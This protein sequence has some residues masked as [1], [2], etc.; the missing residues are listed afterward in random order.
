MKISFQDG[1]STLYNKCV[2]CGSTPSNKTPTAISQSIEDIYNT[3]YNEGYEDGN[4]SGSSG[5]MVG[6][7]IASDV[8]SGKTFTNSTSV[9]ISGTMKNN[10]TLN[11]SDENT[12]KTITPGYYSGGTLDS[13]PSYNAG[14]DA[15]YTEGKNDGYEQGYEE[16]KEEGSIDKSYDLGTLT[17]T[18]ENQTKTLDC[19]SVPNYQSLTVDNF[20]YKFKNEF[21]RNNSADAGGRITVELWG[22][23]LAYNAETGT[24]SVRNCYA[25]AAAYQ[26]GMTSTFVDSISFKVIP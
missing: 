20:Y 9:G 24:L 7:A 4:D 21:Y 15:G 6:T 1:V 25:K 19:K 22:P 8:L 5:S 2:S 26:Y 12:T 14:H 11:W 18:A 16:G 13:R 17:F 10:G 23:N 3:R